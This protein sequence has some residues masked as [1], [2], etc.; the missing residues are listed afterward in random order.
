MKAILYKHTQNGPRKVLQAI[1]S[2]SICLMKNMLR[3]KFYDFEEDIRWNH[4][5]DFRWPCQ[6]QGK[7][8]LK[9]LNRTFLL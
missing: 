8:T 5:F 1:I 9:F 3:Q 4:W 7:V 2:E 6:S